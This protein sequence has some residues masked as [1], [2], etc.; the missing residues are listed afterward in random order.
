LTDGSDGAAK[1]FLQHQEGFKTRGKGVGATP[2]PVEEA[3]EGVDLPG[4][5]GED[6]EETLACL[7]KVVERGP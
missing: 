3:G 5:E 6:V 2:D 1:P 4:E 7:G